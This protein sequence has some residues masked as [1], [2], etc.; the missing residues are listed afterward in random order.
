MKFHGSVS[1]FALSLALVLGAAAV[2]RADDPA[3]SGQYL[4]RSDSFPATLGGSSVSVEVI[5]PA[6][7]SFARPVVIICHGWMVP[8]SLYDGMARHL[9]SRGFAAVLF[10]QPNF[11]SNDTQSWANQ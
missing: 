8:T 5:L 1:R 3:A 11:Y 6:A 7:A 2:A 10:E 4:V 9:A